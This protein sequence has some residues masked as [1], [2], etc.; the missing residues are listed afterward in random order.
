MLKINPLHV[1]K[2]NKIIYLS[3]AF[4]SEVHKRAK[5]F[6]N[7]PLYYNLRLRKNSILEKNIFYQR[8]K[9]YQI[10]REIIGD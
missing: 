4:L 7:L 2:S 6:M 9:V 5:A 10:S 3:N 1:T 8:L